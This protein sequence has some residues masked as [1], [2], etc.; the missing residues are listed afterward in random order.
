MDIVDVAGKLEIVSGI[1]DMEPYIREH[2]GEEASAYVMGY[3]R[4]LECELDIWRAGGPSDLA[5][6]ENELE[7]KWS[8]FSDIWDE[9]QVIKS[10]LKVQGLSRED[11]AAHIQEIELIVSNQL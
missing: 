10:L 2:L 3:I 8:A 6:Y 11:M 1:Q 5:A 9:L 4:E 7:E